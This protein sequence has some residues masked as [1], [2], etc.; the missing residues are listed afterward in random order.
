MKQPL[1]L[2]GRHSSV[3]LVFMVA[4]ISILFVV[5]PR[6]ASAQTSLSQCNGASFD[7]AGLA[8]E[9]HYTVTNTLN[10]SVTGSTVTLQECHGEANK[11]ATLVCTSSTTASTDL[12]TLISQCNNTGNGGGGTMVC[13][14]DVVNNITGTV[15]P[16][17]ATV[18]QCNGSGGGGG[19]DPLLCSPYPA[20]T[21]TATVTQCNGSAN[22]GGGTARVK[23][24][25]D[26]DS[27]TTALVPVRVA[28][29]N[30]SENLGGSTVTCR[31]GLTDNI[32][33]PEAS[34]TPVPPDDGGGDVS[35]EGD[36]KDKKDDDVDAGGRGRPDD[37]QTTDETTG[38][39]PE[40][41]LTSTST[42]GGTTTNQVTRVPEG[43]AS[44]GG[45]STQGIERVNLFIVG[46]LL[47]A[48]AGP[49]VVLGR[50]IN[51]GA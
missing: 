1:G 46:A 30:D 51:G 10:G 41:T 50:R 2:L 9:C 8:I 20:N 24:T 21:T 38:G 15:T 39:V 45:G 35:D 25:V 36:G 32:I 40:D 48:A 27:T 28:Q 37:D 17:S 47:M 26:S 16:A 44:T 7:G 4:L 29:C 6:T 14:V 11:P 3:A 34:P 13:T 5:S 12:V 22:G 49:V 19:A 33:A 18:N 23:C 42:D 43:G 31:V